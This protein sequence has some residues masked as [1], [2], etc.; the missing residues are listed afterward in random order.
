MVRIS[1]N[2]GTT[3]IETLVS[4]VIIVIIA[5]GGM[6]LYYNTSEIKAMS[7][8]KKI[9][10]ELANNRMEEY[11]TESCAGLSNGP[12]DPYSK[13]VGG[14]SFVL[15]GAVDTSECRVSVNVAWNEAD[16]INQDF[17]ITLVTYVR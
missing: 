14:L 12:V 8:H 4:L 17:L 2:Q 5:I 11:R 15:D 6:A 16:R 1:D 7:Q 10:V 9:A 13:L 3:L